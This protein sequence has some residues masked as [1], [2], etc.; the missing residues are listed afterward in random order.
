MIELFF[1]GTGATLPLRNEGMPCI[2]LRRKGRIFIFDFG[3][4]CQ[5]EYFKNGLNVNKPAQIFITHMHG[6]H[7]LG[8]APF[9][10]TLSLQGRKKEIEIFGP[11]GIVEHLIN[12]INMDALK[13]PIRINEIKNSGILIETKEYWIECIRAQHTVEAYSFIFNEKRRPGKFDVEKAKKLGIPEG[14]IRKRLQ[15]GHVVKLGNRFIFPED[16]LGEPRRGAKISYSGDTRFNEDFIRKA[17]DSDILIHESTFSIEDSDEAVLTGHS[18]T[19]DAANAARLSKSKV[20]FL[21]HISSRYNNKR[22]LLEEARSIFRRTYLA[23]RNMR[24]VV[25]TENEYTSLHIYG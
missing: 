6:D 12:T 19:E 14:P 15:E 4:G 13:Y 18:T 24:V 10:Q 25:F 1:L 20:L 17:L 2:I 8:L 11:K 7:F 5:V 22:K 3:E 16:V 21:T 23:R 9:L